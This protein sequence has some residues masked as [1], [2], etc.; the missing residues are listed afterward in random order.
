MK[1]YVFMKN[2]IFKACLCLGLSFSLLGSNIVTYAEE[3]ND[4]LDIQNIDDDDESLDKDLEED[5]DKDS[6]EDSNDDLDKED[7]IKVIGTDNISLSS[8]TTDEDT[9]I[10]DTGFSAEVTA[11]GSTVKIKA[12]DG[13][14]PSDASLSV[15]ASGDEEAAQT[16]ILSGLP[17][18]YIISSAKVFDISISYGEDSN[19]QPDLEKGDVRV[20]IDYDVSGILS[21]DTKEIKVFY[22][23]DSFDNAEEVVSDVEDGEV[24]FYPKHFSKYV[25]VVVDKAESTSN[26]NGN[27][28]ENV[29][30]IDISDFVDSIKVY[31]D[32]QELSD[33]QVVSLENTTFKVEYKLK[34]KIGVNIEDDEKN[35]DIPYVETGDEFVIP[36]TD[37]N[38]LL[39][40]LEIPNIKADG[41]D[42]ATV[43]I[44]DDGIH[45]VVIDETESRFVTD[46]VFGYEFAFDSSS[47]ELK[48][49]ESFEIGIGNV[50][51]TVLIS[52]NQPK[53]PSIVKTG[54]YD[55]DNELI[56]W[57]VTITNDSNPVKYENGYSLVDVFEGKQAYVEDSFVVNE[58][59]VT[60]SSGEVVTDTEN[61][62]SY[63]IDS[64][65]ASAPNGKMTISYSTK[66][67]LDFMETSFKNNKSGENSITFTNNASLYDG[68]K[69]IVS[70]DPAS[71]T[72]KK[73]FVTWV[74]KLNTTINTDGIAEWQVTVNTNGY[75]LKNLTLYD[76]FST[77]ANTTMELVDDSL[78]ID[79]ESADEGKLSNGNA[80]YNFSCCIGDTSPDKTTYVITYKTQIADFDDFQKGNHTIPGNKVWLSYDTDDR[81]VGMAVK[82]SAIIEGINS[83]AGI[84]KEYK[85][86]GYDAANHLITWTVTANKH[87]QVLD[88][89]HIIETPG[90]GLEI[91]A[92]NNITFTDSSNKTETIPDISLEDLDNKKEYNLYLSDGDIN[93]SGRMVTFDVVTK[94]T[95]DAFWNNNSKKSF[96]NS[97]VLKGLVSGSEKEI[98]RDSAAKELTST[99][100]EKKSGRYNYKDHTIDYTISVN[101]N[102]MDMN[103]A[104]ITDD[105]GSAGLELVDGTIKLDGATLSSGNA[106]GNRYIYNKGV[107]R[108]YLSDMSADS[109]VTSARGVITFTA[110][111]TDEKLNSI[112]NSVNETLGTTN[113]KL[114]ITNTA[115]L[116]FDGNES[117]QNVSCDNAIS[118]IVL[119]KDGSFDKS[120]GVASYEVS[121]NSASLEIP[122]GTIIQDTL[123]A[124]FVLDKK[125]VKVYEAD[126]DPISGKLAESDKEIDADAVN[127][128]FDK[129]TDDGK[130]HD[131]LKVTFDKAINVPVV[132]KYN[133]AVEYPEYN[134]VS[135]S[136]SAYGSTESTKSVAKKSI[137]LSG[138]S[139]ANGSSL[140]KI[141]VTKV[142]DEDS[143]ILLKGATFEVYDKDDNLVDTI[144]TNSKGVAKCL[145]GLTDGE[146]YYLIETVAPEGY[147][148]SS[149]PQNITIKNRV[150]NITISNKKI[151]TSIGIELQDTLGELLEGGVLGVRRARDNK[152]IVLTDGKSE[153]NYDTEYIVNEEKTPYGYNTSDDVSFKVEREN[154]KDVLYINQDGEFKKLEDDKVIIQNSK[155][156]NVE[157]VINLVSDSQ[158]EYLTDAEFVVSESEDGSDPIYEWSTTGVDKKLEL[159]TGTYYLVQTKVPEGFISSAKYKL[160]VTGKNLSVFKWDE[161][162]DDFDISVEGGKI[163]VVNETDISDTTPVTFVNKDNEGTLLEGSSLTV[164]EDTDVSK[165]LKCVVATNVEPNIE[166]KDTVLL[167]YQTTY[168]VEQDVTPNGYVTSDPV[169]FKISNDGSVLT[170]VDGAYRET[171]NTS[172]EVIILNDKIIVNDDGTKDPVIE[173][174]DKGSGVKNPII[175]GDKAGE[176]SKPAKEN[177]EEANGKKPVKDNEQRK[178]GKAPSIF[179]PIDKDHLKDSE[180]ESDGED[181]HISSSE[182]NDTFAFSPLKNGS[183][184]KNL[185]D[186]DIDTTDEETDKA[187]GEVINAR[188]L[189]KTG[190]FIGTLFSYAFGIAFLLGGL[191]LIFGKKNEKK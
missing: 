185:E 13:V 60:V 63:L 88:G 18:G 76:K 189:A 75:S 140:V 1:G 96:T 161:E 69:E 7:S 109:S 55:E 117:G 97:V 37:S 87:K 151:T 85:I 30:K 64:S 119:G 59:A 93:L 17:E 169:K 122:V 80:S 70:C 121:Y 167:N 176:A 8:E 10:E 4:I 138:Y 61:K 110:K 175:S 139:S 58:G 38:F 19:Y 48:N 141:V 132:I 27:S 128:S 142:D 54:V 71:V 152:K 33:D 174:P 84:D 144:T 34:S 102:S 108:V 113:K 147:V 157:V 100:I 123:G 65:F 82:V 16:L 136:V 77:D 137:S 188:R 66:P 81:T 41:I 129:I 159:T 131:V 25:L 133:A 86:N 155:K 52:E 163:V 112:E 56:N 15:E 127:I 168:T 101:Q 124:S 158:N 178:E 40:T 187:L 11:G 74:T 32:D 182:N 42:F 164:S 2:R 47:E 120:T 49:I 28:E 166:E 181:Q 26:D 149:V 57:T 154:E 183:D 162:T 143:A 173:Q 153:V 29:T 46:A 31:V 3:T 118:H 95:D 14:L 50:K 179:E 165:A 5:L 21:D 9:T 130:S 116:S 150:G 90:D 78:K 79:G 91:V 44:E 45:L 160:V 115:N 23:S 111:V 148:L 36:K 72:I 67:S 125:S 68:E 156:E 104:V 24:Y 145:S 53:E 73:N 6:N 105:L 184:E 107:L 191:Y 94:I 99:V 92:I 103:N 126:V 98:A 172:S 22:V 146:T 20:S 51:Y 170:L 177:N 114:T 171:D 190:G 180:G 89:S 186:S 35:E 12:D 106:D 62:I 39:K 83:N 135:N 134:D 43:D